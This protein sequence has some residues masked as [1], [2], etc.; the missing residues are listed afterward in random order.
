MKMKGAH[1]HYNHDRNY[2]FWSKLSMKNSSYITNKM[3]TIGDLCRIYDTIFWLYG[4]FANLECILLH[5]LIY[6]N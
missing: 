3:W 2:R 4:Y 5:V 6:S 1:H